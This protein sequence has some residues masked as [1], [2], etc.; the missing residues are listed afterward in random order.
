MQYTWLIWSVILLAVWVIV[1]IFLKEKNSKREMI[2]VSLWTSL[3]G[4]TEPIF[5]PVYWDPPSLFNLAQ[6]TG[7]DIE[8]IIF[9]FA[10]GGLAAVI[11]ELL[12]GVNHKKICDVE[13][14]KPSHKYHTLALYSAPIIFVVLIVLTNWNPIYPTIIALFGGGLFVV[15][16]RPDLK[17]KMIAGSFIFMAIYFV[18]FW[19]LIVIYPEYVTSVWNLESISG[20]LVFGIPLEELLFALGLGFLWSGIYDHIKWYKIIKS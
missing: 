7:F 12:F 6:N 19:T 4:L 8:S 11:Y 10:I 9:A 13:K 5:I 2:I 18:Y 17:K 16:C 15:Y 1:Y 3:L 20:L 14:N